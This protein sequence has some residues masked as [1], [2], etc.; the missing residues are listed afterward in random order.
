MRFNDTVEME[1]LPPLNREAFEDEIPPSVK[2]H[3]TIIKWIGVFVILSTCAVPVIIITS[4]SQCPSSDYD[5]KP[6]LNQTACT[7]VKQYS[8]R[9]NTFATVCNLNGQIWV[10]FRRYINGSASAIGIQ[11]ELK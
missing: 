3:L 1:P 5:I 9:Y 4:T 7:Y 6:D 8:L 2:C 11:L 10:D